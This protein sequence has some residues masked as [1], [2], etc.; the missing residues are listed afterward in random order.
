M[1]IKGLAEVDPKELS[2]GV[3]I[4]TEHLGTIYWMLEQIG[5]HPRDISQDVIY[6]MVERIARDHLAELPDYYSRLV[7]MEGKTHD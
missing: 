6:Q 5:V 1:W 2:Q 4:E 3:E 7:K